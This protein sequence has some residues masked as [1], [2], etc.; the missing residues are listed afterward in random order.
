MTANSIVGHIFCTYTYLYMP[1]FRNDRCLKQPII[2]ISRKFALFTF[3]M[4]IRNV[5][6]VYNLDE[7]C[8]IDDVCERTYCME[9]CGDVDLIGLCKSLTVRV[10]VPIQFE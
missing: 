9:S 5:D 6:A 2:M 10:K 4:R 3:I 8:S 1:V 7:E